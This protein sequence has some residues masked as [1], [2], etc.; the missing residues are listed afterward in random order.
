MFVRGTYDI[1][2]SLYDMIFFLRSKICRCK[3]E[4]VKLLQ[5]MEALVQKIGR[6]SNRLITLQHER[7]R[8]VWK[9]L[10]V[11]VSGLQ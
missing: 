5:Q 10:E 4:L 7:Q 9:L 2:C 1:T 3:Q 11:A 6:A 8:N